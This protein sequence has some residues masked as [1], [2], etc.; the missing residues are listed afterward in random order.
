MLVQGALTNIAVRQ[1]GEVG[2][3]GLGASLLVFGQILISVMVVGLLTGNGY[4]LVQMRIVTTAVCYGFGLAT[5]P[6]LPRQAMRLVR[7]RWAVRMYWCRDSAHLA[8]WAV[9]F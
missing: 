3:V 7:P 2:K 8:K 4:L 1:F 9:W 6:F 5:R